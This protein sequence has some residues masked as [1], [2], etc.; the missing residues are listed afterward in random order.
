MSVTSHN[1]L[2]KRIHLVGIG[3]IGLSAIARVL[4]ARGHCL[5]GSDMRA[6]P[7]LDE[8][9]AQGIATYVGH[10]AEQIGEAELVVMSSAIPESN[11]EVVAAREARVPVIKRQQL[12][13]AMMADSVGIAV[14]GT[15]GKTTTS[16]MIAVMLDR[17]GWDPT[18]IV[19]GIVR[20]LGT[21]ARAGAGQHFV[22]E[23]DEYDR[24]FHG[25]YPAVAVVTNIEMDHPDCYRDLDDMR[26]AFATFLGNVP[27]G[28]TNVSPGTIVVCIDSA[29]VRQVLS[30][31]SWGPREVLTYGFSEDADY[32]VGAVAANDRGGVDAEITH[33][34]RPWATLSLAL[35]GAFNALNATAA[36]IAGAVEDI[37]PGDAAR[38]LAGF[39][40]ARRRFEVRGERD[41]ITVIDDYAH[42]PTEIR[43]TLGAARMRYAGRRLWAV[44]QPHT[45]SRTQTLFAAF[46]AAFGDADRVLVLDIYAAR[47]QEVPTVTS[48]Q[49]VAAMDHGHA[50]FVGGHEAALAHLRAHVA[51]GDVILTLGAGDGDAIG[52]RFLKETVSQ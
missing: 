15:H 42:H 9:A 21:N 11:C 7:L 41:G 36:L 49:L 33:R 23:A 27:S 8:L 34:G 18:F 12:L 48:E 51:A 35:P 32:V 52:E 6:S 14:A 43:A 5:S 19:G 24:M 25:L 29:A 39:V 44:F 40:G 47:A 1:P 2:P 31:R 30:A 50:R 22:I 45:Y 26:E 10:S 37:A 13:G 38:A 46:A 20:D 17:L 3:G 4:A 28:G 16:S